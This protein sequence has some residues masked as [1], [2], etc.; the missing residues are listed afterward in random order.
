MESVLLAFGVESILQLF[1][2]SLRGDIG[3]SSF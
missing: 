2:L 1:P 3:H